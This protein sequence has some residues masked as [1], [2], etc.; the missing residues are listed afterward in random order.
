MARCNKSVLNNYLILWHEKIIKLA[1]FQLD[2]LLKD[3]NG[4]L[5][6][7]TTDAGQISTYIKNG[8][9]ELLGKSK[10]KLHN[11]LKK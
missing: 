10:G 11:F 1:Y 6:N 7:D 5:V 9:W 4:T 3:E 2:L 8:E